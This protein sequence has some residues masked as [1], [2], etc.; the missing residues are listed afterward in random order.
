VANEIIFFD[1]MGSN[2]K[3]PSVEWLKDN[4]FNG[5][6]D[7]WKGATGECT[8]S[9]TDELMTATM[10]LVRRD[11]HGFMIYHR[12]SRNDELYQSLR[13]GKHSGE[14]VEAETGGN[15]DLYFKEYFVPKDIAWQAIEYFLRTGGRDSGLIWEV[16]RMPE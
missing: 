1:S 10:G 8:L 4:V 14:T 15:N 2:E 3:L 11:K 5:G 7:F 12:F 6:D 16:P 13:Y 9:Y